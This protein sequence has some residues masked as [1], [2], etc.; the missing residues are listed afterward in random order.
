MSLAEQP[1]QT[2]IDLCECLLSRRQFAT[3]AAFIRTERRILLLSRGPFLAAKKRAEETPASRTT[4]NKHIWEIN[5]T[6]DRDFDLPAVI[7]ADGTQE[8]Y[9]NGN[10]HRDGDLPA[11]ICADGTREWRKN[12]QRHRDGDLPAVIWAD[13]TQEWWKNG[14]PIK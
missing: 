6:E 12:G 2:I 7:H 8:W 10:L 11:V 13:G 5:D 9:K 14:Q 1:D 3:F 4:E